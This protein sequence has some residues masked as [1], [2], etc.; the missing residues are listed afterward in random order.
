MTITNTIIHIYTDKNKHR[1]TTSKTFTYTHVKPHSTTC[2]HT[3]MHTYSHTHIFTHIYED[4]N[5]YLHTYMY[6]YLPHL[7]IHAH[8]HSHTHTHTNKLTPNSPTQERTPLHKASIK[9]AQ[10]LYPHPLKNLPLLR[11]PLQP[12]NFSLPLRRSVPS[13]QFSLQVVAP[14]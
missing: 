3:C 14:G 9:N 2:T 1:D 7:L 6:N 13:F 8:N 12:L 11:P 4:N 5:I 10:S